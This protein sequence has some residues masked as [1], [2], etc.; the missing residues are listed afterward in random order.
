[1]TVTVWPAT[2]TVPVRS[3][4][5]SW[6]YATIAFA[7]PVPLAGATVRN[8]ALLAVVHWHDVLLATTD[9]TPVPDA[10]P[11]LKDV[12][13]T[14]KRH[15]G[16][17]GVVGVVGVVGVDGVVGVVGV[18]AVVELGVEGVVTPC[19]FVFES[20][21]QPAAMTAA[22]SALSAAEKNLENL[23]ATFPHSTQAAAPMASMQV[24]TGM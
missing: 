24:R 11:T 21:L 15:D 16:E 20:P 3:A 1:L 23:I 6:L 5:V 9:T 18:V 22:P 14:E 19:V 2:V 13:E 4:P 10:D 8:D 12:G 7:E 17:G